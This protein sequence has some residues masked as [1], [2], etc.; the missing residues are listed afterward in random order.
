M[1]ILWVSR[2]KMTSEQ[3]IDLK[4]YYGE[5]EIL[6]ADKTFNSAEEI[7]EYAENIN[8]Y[9]VVLPTEILIKLFNLL[10][11]DKDLL[12]SYSKRVLT[13]KTVLNS[14]TGEYEPEYKFVHDCWK[15]VT[16]AEFETEELK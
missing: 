12:M 6:S 16:H 13:E 8:V 1:R 14:A 10:S 2:H 7:I 5:I 15:R 9:A 3:M 11:D 4:K